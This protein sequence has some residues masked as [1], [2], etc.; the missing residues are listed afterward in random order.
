[1][2]SIAAGPPL[3]QEIQ[4]AL[5]STGYAELQKIAVKFDGDQVSL[6]GSVSSYYQK[7]VAQE[8][9]K[10]VEGVEVLQNEIRVARDREFLF[11][12]HPHHD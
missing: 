7:Q 3:L 2:D 4:K 6:C 9:A 11:S 12:E 1:M 5:M 8:A 10:R